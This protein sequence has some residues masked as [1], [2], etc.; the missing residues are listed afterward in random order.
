M[1]DSFSFD[2]TNYIAQLTEKP[3]VYQMFDSQAE[4]LYVGKAK[5]LKKRIASYFRS[6]GL[7]NKTLSLVK[8]IARIDVTVTTTETEALLLEHNL[9]KQHRPPY[10][11][12][13]RDDKSYPY[14][15]LQADEYPSIKIHRGAKREQGTYFG[16]YPNAS[17]VRE[18]L[19]LM[20]KVFK[21]RQCDDQYYRNRSRACLQYQIKRCTAPCMRYVT[22][23]DYA[24]QVNCTRLFLEG[25]NAQLNTLLSEKM[26]AC[27][28]QQ[29]YEQAAQYRDQLQHL[30]R[31]QEQ[32]CIESGKDELDVVAIAVK[33][34]LLCVHVLFI[35]QG[36]MIG[37]RSYYPSLGIEADPQ[38]ILMSFL[39]QF[40]LVNQKRQIP[41]KIVVQ[42]ESEHYFDLSQAI[43]QLAKRKVEVVG[44]ARGR[45]ENWLNLATTTA[46]ENVKGKIANKTRI[47]ERFLA[48]ASLLP[49]NKPIER[50]ECFDISHSSGEATMASCVTFDR[51]G[52][53][54]SYYRRFTIDGITPGDDYA[55]MQNAL[56][57]RFAITNKSQ[58]VYPDVLLIDGGKGQLG[59]AEKILTEQ[60]INDII[61]IGVAKGPKRR[62][63]FE[64]LIVSLDN[65]T[66]NLKDDHPALHLIQHIR[67]EAH[68]FAVKSHTQKRD[69]KRRKSGLENIPGV[70]AKRRKQL[71]HHFGSV[72]AVKDAPVRELMRVPMISAKI[73]EDIFAEFHKN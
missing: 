43:S 35:R 67:D 55:A 22:P 68:R 2:H 58:A 4:L 27:A 16:P 49:L 64:Q 39:G 13:L 62:A 45:V 26:E 73:A 37:S 19:N 6:R 61:L 12:L 36:R 51:N 20:Q 59:I 52:P 9:I 17:S 24:E 21:V 69:K 31:V 3:G 72:Q 60:N 71:L 14:I 38:S 15:F 54:K 34:G 5:N 57:Q 33:A 65:S 42:N 47:H 28:A 10:N 18:T 40:Y 44:P 56:Q 7:N 66:L 53:A 30:Q 50:M 32:Q 1:P 29:D 23:E 63:G 70:G 8:K 41:S 11:I 46:E 48:L 25:K